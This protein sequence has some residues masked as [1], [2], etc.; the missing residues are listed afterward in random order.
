MATAIHK[1][2][3]RP[4]A[5]LGMKERGLLKEGFAA[6]IVV[7]DPE[8]VRDTADYAEP[9][10]YPEGIEHVIVNGRAVVSNGKQRP[11][12]AGKVVRFSGR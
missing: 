5:V 6:D 8:T 12:K 1:M 10:R 3:G 7:F 4:A 2:T 9:I 11:A